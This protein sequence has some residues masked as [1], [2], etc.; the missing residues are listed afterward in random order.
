MGDMPE[1]LY[2]LLAKGKA[3][4]W[5]SQDKQSCKVSWIWLFITFCL[6]ENNCLFVCLFVYYFII[7]CVFL[8]N[9]SCVHFCF[10]NLQHSCVEVFAHQIHSERDSTLIGT[11]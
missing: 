4:L 1:I 9:S 2:N 5:S 11:Q 10:R 8:E 6:Q 7:F 3:V